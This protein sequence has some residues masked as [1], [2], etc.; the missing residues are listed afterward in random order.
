[1]SELAIRE[2]VLELDSREG[3][4]VLVELLYKKF[5]DEVRIHLVDEDAGLEVNFPVPRESARDAFAHPFHYYADY[6]AANAA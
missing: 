1:M 3:S 5:A 2:R 4:G 6:E